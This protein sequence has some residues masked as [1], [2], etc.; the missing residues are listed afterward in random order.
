MRGCD[1]GRGTL[2]SCAAAVLLAGCSNAPPADAPG[3]MPQSATMQ[4]P[5]AHTTGTSRSD[6]LYVSRAAS[7]MVDAYT[8]PG[9]K[10]VN[11]VHGGGQ[12]LCSDDAGNVFVAAGDGVLEYAHGGTTRIE[13][14]SD[15]NMLMLGCAVD[16]GSGNLAVVGSAVGN[17]GAQVAIYQH[18][19]GT[20]TVYTYGK[21]G[22]FFFCTYDNQ[23][24]VFTVPEGQAEDGTLVELVAGGSSLNDVSIGHAYTGFGHPVQWDGQYLAVGDAP[25][26]PKGAGH[27]YQ[28]Q[29]S[30]STGTVVN[31]IA[32]S[33]KFNRHPEL[34]I[35]FW[36]Q[37]NT[38]INPEDYNRAVGFWRYP[39]GGKPTS[40]VKVDKTAGE[41]SG[42]TVSVAPSR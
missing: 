31:T 7:G 18:V 42:V 36:I 23:G 3:M 24:N 15:P 22:S 28:I 4:Q 30:G 10:L 32:L 40:A 29:V 5:R 16:P 6:L 38:F 39:K 8:Y 11:S 13:T 9:G 17:S 34:G 12:G 35:Q 21:H 20:P 19:Q 27:I 14:L 33:E 26:K 25:D 37:G 1:F 2:M 41:I